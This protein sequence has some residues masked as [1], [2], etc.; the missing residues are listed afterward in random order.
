MKKICI[1]TIHSAVNYGAV[2][3]AYALHTYLNER[4]QK[5]EIIDFC[6][7]K[8]I[9]PKLPPIKLKNVKSFGV[10]FL[11]LL[12]LS[13][14]NSK[15]DKFDNFRKK[16][17]QL[18]R[19]Y[20]SIEDLRDNPPMC[21]AVISGSDQVFNPNRRK[22]EREAFYLGFIDK[23]TRKISYAASFG[24]SKISSDQ[25][26]EI[27]GYLKDFHAISIREEYGVTLVNR[28]LGSE[29]AVRVCDPVFLIAEKNWRSIE[30]ARKDLPPKYILVFTIR[31]R[32][33][34]ITVAEDMKEKMGYPIV[35]LTDYPVKRIKTG[36]YVFDAGPR[37]FLWMI[38]NAQYV[39]TDSFHG[40]AFSV[41]FEKKVVFADDSASSNER[42]LTL[43][44]RLGMNQCT[45]TAYLQNMRLN[46]ID[47]LSVRAVLGQE[48]KLAQTFI[49]TALGR[50]GDHEEE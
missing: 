23:N 21:D 1:I 18:T 30:V 9:Y 5:S 41:I 27:R 16:Y 7:P 34:C 42:G 2:L 37:E 31:N 26:A 38:D 46:D 36:Y 47:Y 14:K 44:N 45:Y 33:S 22:D 49:E 17:Y 24:S 25:E 20:N 39:V 11:S 32:K 6:T 8:M 3:Q 19:R 4:G 13:S 29:R 50:E 48:R 28:I 12:H 40:T 35:V 15:W 10:F 43:L